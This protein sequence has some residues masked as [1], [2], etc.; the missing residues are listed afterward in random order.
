MVEDESFFDAFSH[1]VF[2]AEQGLLLD[3]NNRAYFPHLTPSNTGIKNA[4]KVIERIAWKEPFN[5]ETCYVSRTYLTRHGAGKFP[6]ECEKAQINAQ[7]SDRTNVPNPYQDS[8]RYGML[9]LKELQERCQSDVGTF[10]DQKSI[11]ITHCNEYHCD[12]K[13]LKN[14]FQGWKIYL[15]DGETRKNIR[16]YQ[17]GTDREEAKVTK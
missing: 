11:A 7:M 2:E 13:L 17:S 3:Q 8:L 12:V 16:L 4:R 1:F 14:V 5:I 15:S 9:D 6:T 10:G